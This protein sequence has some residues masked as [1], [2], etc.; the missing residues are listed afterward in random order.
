M[1]GGKLNRD[2]Y[3]HKT[4][5]EIPTFWPQ[6]GYA[7]MLRPTLYPHWSQLS[8]MHLNIS[9]VERVERRRYMI[10]T[11]WN[12][13][14]FFLGSNQTITKP[15]QSALIRRSQFLLSMIAGGSE[16]NPCRPPKLRWS[17]QALRRNV[18]TVMFLLFFA[19]QV[20]LV[21]P[22]WTHL[23]TALALIKSDA[24][25]IH[26]SFGYPPFSLHS[27]QSRSPT[28]QRSEQIY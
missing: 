11:I 10:P 16:L 17:C 4:Y 6:G 24:C 20:W 19:S 12:F 25:A 13:G 5:L 2:V 8:P 26:S 9:F 14:D 27:T 22:Y 21:S 18:G 3:H 28:H 23:I 15:Q 7:G 1:I